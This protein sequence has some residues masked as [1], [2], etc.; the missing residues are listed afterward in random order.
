MSW[1]RHL[2]VLF[3]FLAAFVR[4]APASAFTPASPETRVGGFE[5]AAQ[6]FAGELSAASREQHHGIGAAYD[7]NASG[8]RFAAGVRRGIFPRLARSKPP[9]PRARIATVG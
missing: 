9:G 6:L 4:P 1:L 5:I 8:Y 3:A 7:E 2:A